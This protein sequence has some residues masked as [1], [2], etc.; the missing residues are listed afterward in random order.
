MSELFHRRRIRVLDSYMSYIDTRAGQ[1]TFVLLHG[2]VAS[3]YVWRDVIPAIHGFGRC[4]APD[5]LGMGNSGLSPDNEY[6]YEAQFSY[7]CEWLDLVFTGFGKKNKIFFLAHEWG[8]ALALRWA[9]V[10]PLR[11]AG[12]VFMEGIFCPI[13][14]LED[15]NSKLM[16]KLY[17]MVR[18]HLN[19][20]EKYSDSIGLQKERQFKL[21]VSNILAAWAPENGLKDDFAQHAIVDLI[22]DLPIGKHTN[23]VMEKVN[24]VMARSSTAMLVLEADQGV[25]S[26][27]GV[28]ECRGW[29][30]VR[31]VTMTSRAV[32]AESS[33]QTVAEHFV[34]F[35]KSVA[36]TLDD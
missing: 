15:I 13:R 30:S 18:N 23:E 34:R 4:L 29:D 2:N 16:Q 3:S 1:H 7:I 5:L 19:Q 32:P 20:M 35:V 26:A 27:V 17:V 9:S 14:Y 36:P 11:V 24:K 22:R 6:G 28:E 10:H 8:A 12:V 21:A 25:F 33:P 31:I